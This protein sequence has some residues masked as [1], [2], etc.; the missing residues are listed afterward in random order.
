MPDGFI[1]LGGIDLNGLILTRYN[2]ANSQLG[3]L[4]DLFLKRHT[5]EQGF[6]PLR[7]VTLWPSR[8]NSVLKKQVAIVD[9][10]NDRSSFGSLDRQDT[11]VFCLLRGRTYPC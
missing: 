8:A 7:V 1:N 4:A 9:V 6:D 11:N 5:L 10:R 2:H 3:H